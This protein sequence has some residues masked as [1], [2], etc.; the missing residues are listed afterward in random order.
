L[1]TSFLPSAAALVAETLGLLVTCITCV[2]SVEFRG[3]G[4]RV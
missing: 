4:L 1:L 3:L 2:W